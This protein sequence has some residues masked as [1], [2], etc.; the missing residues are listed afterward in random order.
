MSTAPKMRVWRANEYEWIAGPT[1][2]AAARSA[3]MEAGASAREYFDREYF[4]EL[5]AETWADIDVCEPGN[6]YA[7][8]TLATA[9]EAMRAPG[10][11][12]T[13]EW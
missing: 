3:C 10:I 9:V 11:I 7:D 5:P 12:M 6:S 4:E 1:L 13:T 8:G 2:L